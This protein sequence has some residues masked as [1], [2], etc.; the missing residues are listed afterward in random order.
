ML[1]LARFPIFHGL[2]ERDGQLLNWFDQTSRKLRWA[3]INDWQGRRILVSHSRSPRFANS[4]NPEPQRHGS[5]SLRSLSSVR[6]LPQFYA[7]R[8]LGFYGNFE[9]TL[10]LKRWVQSLH[11]FCWTSIQR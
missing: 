4:I 10:C 8:P 9:G 7:Q 6:W 5:G 11:A 3:Q 2:N 1:V